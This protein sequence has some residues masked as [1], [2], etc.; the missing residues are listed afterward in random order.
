M[1]YWAVKKPSNFSTQKKKLRNKSILLKCIIQY[2]SN[3]QPNFLLCL[4]ANDKDTVVF[5]EDKL[6]QFN[7]L[8]CLYLRSRSSQNLKS[9]VHYISTPASSFFSKR[10]F[11][12]AE[13]Y[14]KKREQ[15]DSFPEMV[16]NY[17]F[18]TTT[19][20]NFQND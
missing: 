14:L 1:K 19:L 13:I 10:L 16:R 7:G 2:N 4:T 6:H 11:S 20:G 18:Y 12:E 8:Y 3:F 5:I 9:I 17:C 15:D